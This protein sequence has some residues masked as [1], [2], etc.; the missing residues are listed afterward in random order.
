MKLGEGEKRGGKEEE[1][2]DRYRRKNVATG[3]G[4]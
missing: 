4:D 1:G 2:E 3:P